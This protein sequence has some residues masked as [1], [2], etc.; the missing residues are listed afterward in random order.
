[1]A[2]STPV[3]TTFSHDNTPIDGTE[4]VDKENLGEPSLPMLKI[5]NSQAGEETLDNNSKLRVY[6]RKKFH[7]TIRE[8]PTILKG[9]SSTPSNTQSLGISDSIPIVDNDLD[10]PIGLRK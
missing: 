6:S 3:P 8:N 9:Q 4:F 10:I 5:R 1:M 2:C 7:Q